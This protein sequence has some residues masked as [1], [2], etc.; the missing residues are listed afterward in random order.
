MGKKALLLGAGGPLGGL[1]AGA[2]I[3][4]DEM[5]VKFDVVAGA[6]IGSILTLAYSSPAKGF[7]PREALENWVKYSGVSDAIYDALP[8]DYKI[9]QKD[10]GA[11]SDIWEKWANFMLTNNPFIQTYPK[12]TFQQYITDMYF[13][14]LTMWAP[15]TLNPKSKSL[16]RITRQLQFMIDFE[17]LKNCDHEVYINALNITD[18]DITLF[19]KNEIT[20]EHVAAGSSLYHIASPTNIDGKVYA[21]GSYIDCINYEGVLKKHEDIDTIV[22]MNILNKR[23]LIREPRDLMDAYNLS[24]ML[25]F[26]TIAE[27]DTKIFEAKYKGDRNLLKVD[28]EIPKSHAPKACDWSVS[29]FKALRDI[30]YKAGKEFFK[31]NKH[32]LE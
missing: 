20:V 8:V 4:L 26:V 14:W 18:K 30:G 1:E 22:V 16:S 2:L 29:N 25:P 32:L 15:T 12:N 21:E 5:G 19:D 10:A 17:N 6:C 23:A 9:F 13:L 3:A 31:N 24:I 28:F 27:D 11:L 7:T